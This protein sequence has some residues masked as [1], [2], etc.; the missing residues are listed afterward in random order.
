MQYLT[1]FVSAVMRGQKR[2]GERA[3]RYHGNCFG[4]IRRMEAIASV[5]W[6][7]LFQVLVGGMLRYWEML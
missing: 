1:P 6:I 7:Y 4:R 5:L 3:V 2:K